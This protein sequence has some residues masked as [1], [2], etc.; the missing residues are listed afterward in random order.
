MRVFTRITMLHRCQQPCPKYDTL[1]LFHLDS[2]RPCLSRTLA[3]MPCILWDQTGLSQ[4]KKI[5]QLVII[6]NSQT[7]KTNRPCA[8]QYSMEYQYL[9]MPKAPR[10]LKCCMLRSKIARDVWGFLSSS[11]VSQPLTHSLQPESFTLADR[12]PEQPL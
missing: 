8:I 2:A 9:S 4:S 5:N 11:P 10:G 12:S 1:K 3:L 6:T 7:G